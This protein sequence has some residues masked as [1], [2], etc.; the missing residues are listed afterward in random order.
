M[1]IKSHLCAACGC[2]KFLNIFVNIKTR[3]KI[4]WISFWARVILGHCGPVQI[5]APQRELLHWMSR[6]RPLIFKW[7]GFLYNFFCLIDSIWAVICCWL[8][9]LILLFWHCQA[10]QESS[11]VIIL[12]FW[13]FVLLIWSMVACLF[14]FFFFF[15]I[16]CRRAVR[17]FSMM[18][19]CCVCYSGYNS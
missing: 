19:I 2:L 8:L 4:S 11:S 15:T 12:C 14:F 9:L 5:S 7:V 13:L 16:M 6:M 1:L 18:L 10:V 3:N 17:I